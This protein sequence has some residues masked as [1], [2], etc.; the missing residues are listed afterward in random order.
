MAA[1]KP[2]IKLQPIRRCQ[3]NGCLAN[4][5]CSYKHCMMPMSRLHWSLRSLMPSWSWLSNG[6]IGH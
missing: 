2:D 3:N 6:R 4:G 5:M 1:I